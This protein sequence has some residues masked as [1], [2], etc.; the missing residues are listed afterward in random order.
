MSKESEKKMG[1]L[2]TKKLKVVVKRKE[3]IKDPMFVGVD[4]S[5]NGFGIIVL[6]KNAEIVEQRLLTSKPKQDAD[7]RIIALEKEFE[8]IPQIVGLH[9][10]YIEGPSFG[11]TGAFVLQMGAL[12]YYLRIFLLKKDTDFKIVSP[13]DLKKFVTGKG[14]AK[15]ELMLKNVFKKWGADFDDNN[16]ADAYSLARYALEDYKNGLKKTK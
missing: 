9:S 6:D 1:V 16:L 7:K 8:F 14:N 12:H 4:P 2:G 11:S 10:I 13:G 15:K 3:D 5:F